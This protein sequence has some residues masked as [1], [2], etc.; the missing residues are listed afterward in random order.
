[1]RFVLLSSLL[2][3]SLVLPTVARAQLMVTFES[4][5]RDAPYDYTNP[6]LSLAECE[7]NDTISVRVSGLDGT[8]TILDVWRGTGNVDCTPTEARVMDTRTC[9]PLTL[10]ADQSINSTTM[11]KDLQVE[12]QEL[13]DC[14]SG[15]S[16]FQI[17]FLVAN[18]MMS[19]EAV[20]LSGSLSIQYDP[21]GPSAPTELSDAAGD[22]MASTTWTQPTETDVQ[23]YVVYGDGTSVA[24]SCD[25]ALATTTIVAGEALPAGLVELGR[26]TGS[27]LTFDPS[28]LASTYGQ[29]AAIVVVALDRAGNA[30][31]ASNVACATRIE[32]TGFCDA[33]DCGDGCSVAGGA[34]I[35]GAEETSGLALGLGALLAFVLGRRRKKG[36]R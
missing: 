10:M 24:G 19:V 16:Q 3:L 9:E 23:E 27:G 28:A 15:T 4:P 33:Y 7:A 25:E 11:Q 36:A 32:T 1:M 14:T 18:A 5:G 34:G 2:S 13:V 31:V 22:T 20:T 26:S 12:V 30:S 29:S 21:D 8:G 17:W 35:A 6:P